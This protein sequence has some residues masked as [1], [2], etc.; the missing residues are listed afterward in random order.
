MLLAGFAV[1]SEHQRAS[2]EMTGATHAASKKARET[3]GVMDTAGL[4]LVAKAGGPYGAAL[5]LGYKAY[6][7]AQENRRK[8]YDMDVSQ[9][10]STIL[11]RNLV[12]NVAERRF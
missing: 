9:I 4:A 8:L 10:Q 1:V 7:L 5:Y 11:Q 6:A 3:K 2:L 12:K